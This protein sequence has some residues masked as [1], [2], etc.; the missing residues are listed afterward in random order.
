MFECSVLIGNTQQTQCPVVAFW[1]WPVMCQ[2]NAPLHVR[3]NC[4]VYCI[5]ARGEYTPAKWRFLVYSRLWQLPQIGVA[6]QMYP[7]FP[8]ATPHVLQTPLA[9]RGMAETASEWFVAMH[10]HG[11][12]PF[13]IQA[14]LRQLSYLSLKNRDATQH[15]S[16]TW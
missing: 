11:H 8:F 13:S 4:R 10:V 3:S 9:H 15:K 7:C 16:P 6:W 5:R 14:F 12:I 2:V 1:T